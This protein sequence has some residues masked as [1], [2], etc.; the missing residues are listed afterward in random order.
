MEFHGRGA[1][2]EP[3]ISARH[4]H[5]IRSNGMGNAAH[6]E[7]TGVVE[8]AVQLLKLLATAGR[9]G[10][11]LTRLSA[12]TG[13][14]NSTVHRLL[15]Q[16]CAQ[17]MVVQR[18]ANKRYAL[19]ALVFELGLAASSSFDPRDRCAPFLRK[20]A[21]EVGDTVYLTMRSGS[22]AV[23]VD[24]HEGPSPVRVL[25]L[26]VGSRRPLG[27]GAGG[28]AILAY[29]QETERE[30][31][32]QT[33]CKRRLGRREQFETEL[34][35]AVLACRRNGYSLIRN[36]VNPGVSAVGVPLLDSLD[37]PVAAVSVAAIDARMRPAR[38][39]ALAAL[40]Q[41]RVRVIRQ[42]MLEPRR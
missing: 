16:L 2:A 10:M 31:L 18:D 37:Q 36:R 32:I 6:T 38:I 8:R 35:A 14:A 1:L 9:H 21:E 30:E 7:E 15:G 22:D 42:S 12:A 5:W 3:A 4:G 24:R 34:R 29:A 13:L 26:D 20:L 25:T 33:L 27:M 39:T 17:G 28:V 11:A 41:Q 40:L 23:C 19:G